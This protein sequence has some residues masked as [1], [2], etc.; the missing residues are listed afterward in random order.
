VIILM[1][2]KA[3]SVSAGRMSLR[4]LLS[5]Y[6]AGR[7]CYTNYLQEIAGAINPLTDRVYESCWSLRG[8]L[9]L[10]ICLPYRGS[11]KIAFRRHG[12]VLDDSIFR[13]RRA[14]PEAGIPRASGEPSL[15][16]WRPAPLAALAVKMDR[17]EHD[18]AIDHG[19]YSPAAHRRL[20]W[21]PMR[22][23]RRDRFLADLRRHDR[24][25]SCRSPIS[26]HDIRHDFGRNRYGEPQAR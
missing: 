20:F 1:D 6:A 14:A 2:G 11:R 25:S 21:G 10:E 24:S 5:F 23:L 13:V 4:E 19:I 22:T 12:L 9:A 3:A 8:F 17:E 15:A 16:G 26:S 7:H 18:R